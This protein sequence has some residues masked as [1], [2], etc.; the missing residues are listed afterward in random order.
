[1]CVEW[2]SSRQPKQS[3]PL[4]DKKLTDDIGKFYI[5]VGQFINKLTNA[6]PFREQTTAI[7]TSVT[8]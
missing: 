7:Y 2:G 5:D 8:I 4:D 3:N 6:L 1:M